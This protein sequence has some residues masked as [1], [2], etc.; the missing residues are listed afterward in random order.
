MVACVG[1]S[2]GVLFGDCFGHALVSA[3]VACCC[4]PVLLLGVI[5]G[6]RG[7]GVT[8]LQCRPD[9]RFQH[10]LA[11]RCVA[12]A[13]RHAVVILTTC[14]A[15]PLGINGHMYAECCSALEH[16]GACGQG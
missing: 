13:A 9:F 7:V 15:S 11:T 12:L 14:D 16:C 1:A 10:D 6:G 4:A 8:W 3:L 2:W 5:G